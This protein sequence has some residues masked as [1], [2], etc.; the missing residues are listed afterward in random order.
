MTAAG[1]PRTAA[2]AGPSY[3][4]A[5]I[6]A[7]ASVLLLVALFAFLADHAER[8]WNSPRDFGPRAVWFLWAA[9]DPPIVSREPGGAVLPGTWS[10][11][12]IGRGGFVGLRGRPLPRDVGEP[13][14]P[15]EGGGRPWDGGLTGETRE[16]G[17]VTWSEYARWGGLTDLDE[18]GRD[19]EF[20]GRWRAGG[21]GLPDEVEFASDGTL[22]GDGAPRPLG[23]WAGRDRLLVVRRIDWSGG[24]VRRFV[25]DPSDPSGDHFVLDEGCEIFSARRLR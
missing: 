18:L 6:G 13:A 25:R 17:D 19:A 7:G 11:Y 2:S 15:Q 3:R 20:V 23:R 22:R 9:G 10:R 1:A 16:V 24:S 4:W 12:E 5:W 21:A 8:K 14:A